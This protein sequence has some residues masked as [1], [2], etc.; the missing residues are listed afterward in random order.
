MKR[1]HRSGT[2]RMPKVDL[3]EGYEPPSA[4]VLAG[5]DRGGCDEEAYQHLLASWGSLVRAVNRALRE[6]GVPDEHYPAPV[7]NAVDILRQALLTDGSGTP[8]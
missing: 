6:L 7:A 5:A 8:Q 4:A 3:P 1:R 2:I